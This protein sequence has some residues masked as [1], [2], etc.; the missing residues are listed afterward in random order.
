MIFMKIF[1]IHM[2]A[3]TSLAEG[4]NVAHFLLIFCLC[5][6][7]GSPQSHGIKCTQKK[8]IPSVYCQCTLALHC[9]VQYIASAYTK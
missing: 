1:K 7:E 9:G 5:V 2:K 8:R 6:N 4:K 3:F